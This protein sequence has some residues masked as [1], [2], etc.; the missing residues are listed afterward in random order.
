MVRLYIQLSSSTDKDWNPRMQAS[1]QQVQETA[2]RVLQPFEIE[3]ERVDWYSVYP[4]G[5]GIS[6]KYT[7]DERVFLGGDACHTHSVSVTQSNSN[8]RLTQLKPKAGQGMNTAFLDAHNLAWKIHH[9]E[10]GF[11]NRSIL[12]TYERERRAVAESLLQFDAEY[13]KLFSTQE[14]SGQDS[15]QSSN[16]GSSSKFTDLFKSSCE[17]TSGYGTSYAPNVFNWG[18]C[19][20]AQSHLFLEHERGTTLRIGRLMPPVAVRRVVDANAVQLEYEVPVNGAFR[21]YVFAGNKTRNQRAL[22]DFAANLNKDTSFYKVFQR[23]DM[24]SVSHHEQHLPHS[25]FFSICTIFANQ[26]PEIEVADL[27]STLGRYSSQIYADDIPDMRMLD[28]K[29]VAH[30]KMGLDPHRGGV[31][32]ARPDGHV[33]CVLRLVEGSETVDAL[34]SYFSAFTARPVGKEERSQIR[35]QL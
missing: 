25:R 29:A 15:R 27:P 34:N 33:G 22:Q 23:P 35:A 14:S 8:R 2:K 30:A 26:R 20:P 18:S 21:I 13:A 11:A 1:E 24:V 31:V 5:Q 6:D 17:F 19:H 32:V 12:S 10:S 4:I 28:A 9:V 16:S 3:W 7:L